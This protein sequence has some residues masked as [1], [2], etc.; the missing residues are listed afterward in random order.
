ML[1]HEKI[2]LGVGHSIEFGGA[3]WD[4]NEAS[5]RNRYLT[6]DGK[7]SPHSSSELSLDDLTILIV[8]S[9]ARDIFKI[10]SIAR[11]LTA[12]SASISRQA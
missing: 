5:V 10:P 2:E 8:E 12:L 6:A 3:T 7:F 9:A 1:V 4:G 11:M